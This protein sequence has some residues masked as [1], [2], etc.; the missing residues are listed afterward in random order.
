MPFTL[1]KTRYCNAVQCP[2]MLWLKQYKPEV[3]DDSVMN[4]AVL[5]TG[6]E[7]GDLAMGLFGDFTEVP[8]GNPSEMIHTTE[9]LIRRKT[10]VI[11]EASFS[12]DGLFCS[13]DILKNLGR[14]QVELYEVKSSTAIH[15]IYIDDVSYQVYVLTQLGCQVKRACLVHLNREY[16][17]IGELNLKELFT[18]ED[19]TEIAVGNHH[20]VEENIESFRRY[21]RKRKEPEQNLGAQ[22][23]S[24]YGCGFWPYCSKALPKPNVFDLKRT[25]LNTKTKL[26]DQG[27]VSYEDLH[28]SGALGK[29]AAMQVSYEL[30]DLPDRINRESIRQYLQDITY[31]LYFLDFESFQP[32]VPL[33]DYSSPYDQIPFQ[34]SLHYQ[35]KQNGKLYHKEY[36]AYPYKDPRRGLAEQLCKDI[37]DDVCVLA[38]SMTFEKS[39]IKELAEL[40]PDLSR[41]LM[42]IHDN[43]K[44]LIVPFQQN[45]YNNKAMQGSYSIKYVLPALFPG[46]PEL[47]YQNLEGVHNGREASDTF[48]LMS[49]MDPKA[50]EE[51][52]QHLL[53]YCELDTYAMVKVLQKLYEAAEEKG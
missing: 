10:P 20:S 38:Y 24:P 5:Q 2:K 18:F 26:Y 37:P 50:L 13:V 6:N 51:A 35:K 47:D 52:R 48:K 17:R 19:L 8:Y 36:L 11:C 39:R 30:E 34:Y 49:S 16:V 40:F 53:K 28:A 12:Y 29:Q 32:A 23:F 15:D 22:C 25:Q 31:P 3:F 14:K 43:I 7:V 27:L 21:M 9:E 33:Y 45:W 44:D 46:D 41:H 4:E 42:S 1:S